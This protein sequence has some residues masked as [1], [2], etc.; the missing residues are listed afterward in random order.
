[1]TR[2]LRLIS[3]TT[4]ALCVSGTVC[5]GQN[6]QVTDVVSSGGTTPDKALINPWGMSRSAGSPW[7]ISDNGT[8][9]STLYTG[10][11]MKEGLVVK[12]PAAVAGKTGSPTGTIYNGSSTDFLIAKGDPAIFLFC[13]IDGTIAGWNPATGLTAGEKLPSTN[14][15]TLIKK[16]D[17]SVYTGLTSA[18]VGSERYLYAAN[19]S[20][21][22]VDVWDSTFKPVTFPTDPWELPPFT[23]DLLPPEY[24]P[25]NVQAIGDEIVV[26]YALHQPGNPV[27]TDGPGLGY[28]DV[29]SPTG[30]LLLHLE[31]G[32]WL[33]APWG[34]ALAP[35]DFG[36]FSH[37]LLIGQFAGGG[38]T[39]GSGWIAAYNLTTGHFEGLLDDATGKPIAIQGIWALSPGNVSPNNLDPA[40]SPAAAVYFTAGP[41][42][43]SEGLLG[44]LTAVSTELINGND[45]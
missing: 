29:Y 42:G 27:E 34:V 14:A 12:I 37:A 9:L 33:N 31:H 24:V 28:V 18:Q 41:N 17:G 32:V 16:K 35:L 40:A 36:Q 13:T 19:F 38:T 20:K 1:M 4:L 11:G 43:G 8:G 10:A 39:E 30:Y 21:G 23:D 3:G 15:V 44:Y 5:F 45:Q 26:T 7:W 25:F 2:L 6:Y 22:S